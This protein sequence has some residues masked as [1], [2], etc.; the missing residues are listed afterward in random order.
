MVEEILAAISLGHRVLNGVRAFRKE[1]ASLRTETTRAEASAAKM[2][3]LDE[4]TS[5]L[6]IMARE[7]AERTAA[8]ERLLKESLVATEAVAHR[9]GVIFWIAVTGCAAGCLA[10]I[11]AIIAL[12]RAT[13]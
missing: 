10:L 9:V 1:A 8:I 12:A 6:E 13:H 7:Q 4:R 11:L 2:D 5:N 3:A